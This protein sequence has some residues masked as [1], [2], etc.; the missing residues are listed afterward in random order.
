MITKFIIPVNN[1]FN[2]IEQVSNKNIKNIN[3]HV[4]YSHKDINKV[5]EYQRVKYE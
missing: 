1:K 3:T 5:K 2:L 4:L